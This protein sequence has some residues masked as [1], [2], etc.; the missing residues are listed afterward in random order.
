MTG[1]VTTSGGLLL[2]LLS[3]VAVLLLASGF[4]LVN[5]DAISFWEDESW[6]A[7]AIDDTL[8][9][10]WTFAT[11]RGVH[12]PL[13]FM[14][15][16]GWKQIA[17]NSEL[18]LRWMGGLIVV[19]GLALT[20]RTGREMGGYRAGFFAVLLAAGM[21]YLIYLA[22]LAR[23][24]TLFYTL[25]LLVT[26]FYLRWT[27]APEIDNRALMGLALSQAALMLTHYFGAWLIAAIS[28]HC[29]LTQP[30]RRTL[31]FAGAG[32][33]SA[34][35]FLPW[36]PSLLTQLNTSTHGSG[37]QYAIRDHRLI[38]QSYLDR[39]TNTS[40]E[41]G[42][43]FGLLAVI[44]LVIQRRFRLI[45]LFVLWLAGVF[46]LILALNERFAWYIGRNILYATG[47]FVLF[48]GMGLAWLSRQHRLLI[49]VAT[50]LALFFVVQGVS[51]YEAFWQGAETPNWRR[52]AVRMLPDAKPDDVFVVDGESYS[53]DYYF[54]RFTGD[55]LRFYDMDEWTANPA[56][57]DRIWLIDAGMAVNFEAIDALPPDVIQTRRLVNLPLV[58]E[59]YR[60][61]PTESA[62]VFGD[63][64]ALAHPDSDGLNII[65]GEAL[66]LE[67]WW[68]AIAVADPHYKA[69]VYLVHETGLIAQH[70]D[71][72]D[73][74]RLASQELPQGQ[75][76][77]DQR[78]LPV[79]PD[80]PSGAYVIGV[81]VY[82][83]ADGTRLAVPGTEDDLYILSRL[84]LP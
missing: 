27:R 11:E 21:I 6:M 5:L 10:V 25:T 37:I 66:N 71:L 60:L 2:R 74:G 38:V 75:W 64:I 18:A 51:R 40:Y 20:Y 59:F 15:A 35:L 70:D 52:M 54:R 28:L 73:S 77:P 47:G 43:L 16:W 76:L 39:M 14:L 55:R 67:L 41:M 23:Q 29:L 65:R 57:E 48:Y 46:L 61:P 19:I 63:Q 53:L 84:T 24:Y 72:F 69:G 12:P 17:G 56:G 50:G 36:V 13:Y 31:R 42:G 79:P 44:A 9:D 26:L 62:V 83:P 4:Y 33:V 49:P 30:L 81:A 68:Q 82:N 78:M 45:L 1:S 3:L 7:I 34:L 22:R 8:P 58:T 32:I 80:A